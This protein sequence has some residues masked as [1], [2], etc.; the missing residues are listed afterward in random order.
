M[1]YS[2]AKP[3]NMDE[4]PE[5]VTVTYGEEK[6]RY[7]EPCPSPGLSGKNYYSYRKKEKL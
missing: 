3:E 5:E 7:Y 1:I 4:Q 6:Y 2:I